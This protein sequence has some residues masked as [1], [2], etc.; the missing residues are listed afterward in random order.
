MQASTHAQMIQNVDC[1]TSGEMIDPTLAHNG[2]SLSRENLLMTLW[3]Y[4][5]LAKEYFK[6]PCLS[7]DTGPYL[8][9]II[10]IEKKN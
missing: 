5:L 4:L 2:K 10:I 8:I 3:Q 7:H 6:R 9:I 1:A